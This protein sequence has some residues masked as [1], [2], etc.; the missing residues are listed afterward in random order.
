VFF[1][2]DI[3]INVFFGLFRDQPVSAPLPQQAP[4]QAPP[5]AASMMGRAA[6]SPYPQNYHPVRALSTARV[7]RCARAELLTPVVP[8]DLFSFCALAAAGRHDVE[9]VGGRPH[10]HRL[11]AAR[12]RGYTRPTPDLPAA[13]AAA[14]G[15]CLRRQPGPGLT[16]RSKLCLFCCCLLF[17][18]IFFIVVVSLR[19][20]W[21]LRLLECFR[22]FIFIFCLFLLRLVLALALFLCHLVRLS[23]IVVFFLFPL[24]LFSLHP[25][26][27]SAILRH[28]TAPTTPAS[29]PAQLRRRRRRTAPG[30]AVDGCLPVFCCCTTTSTP[31]FWNTTPPAPENTLH[32]FSLFFAHWLQLCFAEKQ[33]PDNNVVKLISSTH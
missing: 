29:V 9:L 33:R 32:L 17:F 18:F 8:L 5:T 14:G 12:V 2:I 19:L 26:K 27:S 28:P 22:Y 30:G 23:V 25:A 13:A 10:R 6:Y 31:H 7:P 16:L 15:V 20:R 21:T 11:A 4:L 24:F 1:L 3:K